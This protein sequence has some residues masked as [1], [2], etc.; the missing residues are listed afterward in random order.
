MPATAQRPLY[1]LSGPLTATRHAP[2]RQRVVLRLTAAGK[3]HKVAIIAVMRKLTVLANVL[4]RDGRPWAE[5]A[6][7]AA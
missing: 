5:T 4:L 6:P 2:E 1:G 7:T 3:N